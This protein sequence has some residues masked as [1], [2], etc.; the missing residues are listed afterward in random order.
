[1]RHDNHPPEGL[2]YAD[3]VRR[4]PRVVAGI[5]VA[6]I[7]VGALWLAL[8]S[9]AY[10]ASAEVLVSPVDPSQPAFV[11]IDVVHDSGDA[12]RPVQTAVALLRSP[13]AAAGA[14]ASLGGRWTTSDIERMVRVDPQGESSLV[15]VTA[16]ATSGA[17]AVRLAN[18][19]ARASLQV[20][21]RAVGEQM[22]QRIA[23]LDARIG[24][25][26]PDAAAAAD[27]AAERETLALAAGADP[28]LSLAER[29]VPPAARTG[30]P[31][32]F[33]LVLF[34]LVGLALGVATAFVLDVFER[35]GPSATRVDRLAGAAPL[36]AAPARRT[37][38]R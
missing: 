28:S 13:A 7:L 6:A 38:K 22:R 33:M 21:D 8:R 37:R 34:T 5:A 36:K 14:R 1:M 4:H 31:A 26:P 30:A 18:A 9:P 19:Y 29:A 2:S 12:T 23:V 16:R 35:R 15:D 11:G 20:R 27:L 24:A 25:A 32:S 10:E 17:D 3:A